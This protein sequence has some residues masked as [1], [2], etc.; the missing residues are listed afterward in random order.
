MSAERRVGARLS[1]GASRRWRPGHSQCTIGSTACLCSTHLGMN[2]RSCRM[3]RV[4]ECAQLIME[5]RSIVSPERQPLGPTGRGCPRT[6]RGTGR[7]T[8]IIFADRLDGNAR[9]AHGTTLAY[10]LAAY[11]QAAS[12][13]LTRALPG[14]LI[15]QGDLV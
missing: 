3:V 9:N 8:R 4:M 12:R 1:S 10:T 11:S 14:L 6:G 13:R 15:A 7:L 2:V 5:G